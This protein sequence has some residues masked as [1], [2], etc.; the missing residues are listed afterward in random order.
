MRQWI[1]SDNNSNQP[2]W[3]GSHQFRLELSLCSEVPGNGNRHIPTRWSK[4]CLSSFGLQFASA[5]NMW[6]GVT[7]TK[8]ESYLDY[9]GKVLRKQDCLSGWGRAVGVGGAEI[10]NYCCSEAVGDRL[11]MSWYSKAWWL[12]RFIDCNTQPEENRAPEYQPTRLTRKETGVL[13]GENWFKVMKKQQVENWRWEELQWL[14]LVSGKLEGHICYVSLTVLTLKELGS[15]SNDNVLSG[16]GTD[17]RPGSEDRES[18]RRSFLGICP[19]GDFAF[20]I[21]MCKTE[22]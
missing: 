7:T 22:L 19:L 6:E 11:L 16:H 15:Q 4:Y 14:I 18:G 1:S 12:I 2:C 21:R 5:E 20:S 13:I 10:P 3:E 9:M 8:T 17:K